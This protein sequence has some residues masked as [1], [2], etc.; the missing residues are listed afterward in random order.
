MPPIMILRAT[1]AMMSKIL[2][3]AAALVWRQGSATPPPIPALSMELCADMYDS[4]LSNETIVPQ[5]TF[6]YTLCISASKTSWSRV[7]TAGAAKGDALIFNG[8]HLITLSNSP[9]TG[10]VCTIAPGTSPHP[11]EEPPFSLFAIPKTAIMDGATTVDGVRASVWRATVAAEGKSPES[12]LSFYADADDQL[13]RRESLTRDG[14][15]DTTTTMRNDWFARGGFTTVIPPGAFLP[16]S[17]ADC[18]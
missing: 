15:P 9:R 1:T 17:G 5:L 10:K 7:E 12:W 4:T 18:E 13:V 11:L 3:C 2:A 8:T 14:G 16:P 6:N